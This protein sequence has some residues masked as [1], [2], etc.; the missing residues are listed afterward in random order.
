LKLKSPP[1]LAVHARVFSSPTASTF[2][3]S[4]QKAQNE[5]QAKTTKSEKEKEKFKATNYSEAKFT[6]LSWEEYQNLKGNEKKKEESVTGAK[7][8][9]KLQGFWVKFD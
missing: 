8:G 2:A 9:E 7:K 6:R 1:L 3:T 4:T 5:E